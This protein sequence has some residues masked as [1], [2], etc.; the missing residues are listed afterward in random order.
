MKSLQRTAVGRFTID[1][2]QDIEDEPVLYP[3]SMVLDHLP[4]VEYESILEVYQGKQ[5]HINEDEPLVCIT[6]NNEPVA[7]YENIGNGIY[8]SK[9]GLW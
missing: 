2:A 1:M 5:I 4:F 7:I 9:R 3:V 8:K 6:E